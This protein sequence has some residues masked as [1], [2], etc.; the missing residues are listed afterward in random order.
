M[1]IDRSFE[2]P[3]LELQRNAIFRAMNSRDRFRSSGAGR[4]F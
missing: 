1:F 3:D 2:F 4:I